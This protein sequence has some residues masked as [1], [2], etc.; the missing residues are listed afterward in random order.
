MKRTLA[1]ILALCMVFSVFPLFA[2]AEEVLSEEEFLLSEDLPEI[3]EEL[4]FEEEPAP[5]ELLPEILEE[6]LLFTEELEEIEAKEAGTNTI[7]AAVTEIGG[8]WAKIAVTFTVTDDLKNSGYKLCVPFSVLELAPDENGEWNCPVWDLFPLNED[9]SLAGGGTM[10]ATIDMLI[11]GL[12][13][14]YCALIE[15]HDGNIVRLTEVK[16]FTAS[17]DTTGIKTL[18]PNTYLA[19][20][21]GRTMFTFT[22]SVNGSF[23][24]YGE[25]IKDIDVQTPAGKFVSAAHFRGN[26]GNLKC[27]FPAKAG[28]TLYIDIYTPAA[29]GGSAVLRND[30]EVQSSIVTATAP[31][32]VTNKSAEIEVTLN[33]T[34]ATA[35]AG[36]RY[37]IL[38]S[39]SPAF[40]A[41][42]S[43]HIG[44]NYAEY[45]EDS[46]SAADGQRSSI[47]VDQL[48]PGKKYY[49][50]GVIVNASDNTL[51]FVE[52]GLHSFMTKAGN[53]GITALTLN[54]TEA[55]PS[56]AT[57]YYS[58]TPTENGLYVLL[59]K[60]PEYFNLYNENGTFVSGDV[61]QDGSV[62]HVYQVGFAAKA[63]KPVYIKTG[64]FNG[65]AG[66]TIT[67]KDAY[68]LV[69][70]IQLGKFTQ[71][72][73]S[74]IFSFTAPEAGIY[75]IRTNKSSEAL[76]IYNAETGGWDWC[77]SNTGPI[78]MNANETIYLV[79]LFWSYEDSMSIMLT[80][81]KVGDAF[82]DDNIC[83][84]VLRCYSEALGR[85]D[86]EIQADREGVLYWYNNLKNQLIS[87]DYVGYYFVFSPEGASKGQ[88]NN[89]FVTMLYRLYM[90]RIPDE[91]GLKYWDNL[92]NS[93]TLTRENVNWWFCE[94]AEWQG[95]KTEFG[96]K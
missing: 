22:A 46:S 68:G 23:A 40:D 52:S 32:T 9:P 93:G 2:M 12:T 79:T 21:T 7:S 56:Q 84:F 61:S 92:L 18:T 75:C 88:S 70:A 74:K 83:R 38:V 80:A 34:E 77:G 62:S 86:A 90:N 29:D 51:L 17:T 66:A 27:T 41:V 59:S 87:A 19:L 95:I 78:T 65:A 37:G 28:E 16:Q 55:I 15:D 69:D 60:G 11:P 76:Q 81:E 85:T 57:S 26:Y 72:Y 73:D 33:V 3:E 63:G 44:D 14:N 43:Y 5:E 94:S 42:A 35:A 50:C 48:A 45:L 10:V 82:P 71:A 91:G 6:E 96:M 24:I 30:Q 58:F 49:Y 54:T 89:A 67:I 13:Y 31:K 25:N 47:L 64:T 4:F 20:P 39:A 36:Y 8:Y 1:I 53:S